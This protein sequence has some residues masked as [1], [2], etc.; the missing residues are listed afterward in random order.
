MDDAHPGGRRADVDQSAADLDQQ[1]ADA[2]Q[3]ASR[4]DQMEADADQALADRDQR[5]SD[6]DQAAADWE[7]SRA[8]DGTLAEIAHEASRLERLAANRERDSIAAVRLRTTAQR[9]ATADRR[10]EAAHERDLAAT[11][12]DRAA[13]S[14][15][16]QAGSDRVAAASDR[17]A[18]ATDR[19]AAAVDR[20]SGSL[21]DLTG[22]LRRAAGELAIAHEIDRSRRTGRPMILAIVDVDAL[23]LVNE[24]QGHAAG[25]AL[26]HDVA[27]AI[28]STLRSYDVTAR[29][30]GGFV[31]ALS[32]VTRA[33]ASAH[34]AEIQRALRTRRPEASVS[35][36][37]AELA[38]DD[39]LSTLS[40]RA[41][42]AL[43]RTKP[44]ALPAH[45]TA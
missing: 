21:D 37:L 32:D 43:R 33:T 26:L 9:G 19:E 15:Q 41:A 30:G 39:T 20:R 13:Q 8:P 14:G 42:V 40:T 7:R 36:G 24:R 12:R 29:C 34:A 27:R 25:D 38:D 5:A 31:C 2:D 6:R 4:A 11:A 17:A 10:D 23:G 28:T 18:A 45:R 44:P 16:Q 35:V 3:A 22:V 1:Q